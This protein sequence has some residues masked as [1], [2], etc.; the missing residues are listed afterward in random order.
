MN[1][2]EKQEK[3][4][5]RI[6][7]AES[8]LAEADAIRNMGYLSTALNRYYYACFY[9]T[10]ALLLTKELN[11]KTHAGVRTLFSLH[12][13]QTGIIPMES[14][15]FFSQ[16]FDKRQRSDYDDYLDVDKETVDNFSILAIEFIATIKKLL[17][18]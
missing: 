7:H 8:T 5:Y 14:G 13:I 2:S 17:I 4:K 1:D 15:Q 16:L 3:I 18:N 11:P 9:A 10:T 12:F 6:N